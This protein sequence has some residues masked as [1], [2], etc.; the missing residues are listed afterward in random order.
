MIDRLN[1]VKHIIIIVS[2]VSSFRPSL[3]KACW[4]NVCVT[5]RSVAVDSWTTSSREQNR[6]SSDMTNKPSQAYN[7]PVGYGSTTARRVYIRVNSPHSVWKCCYFLLNI[8]H[9]ALQLTVSCSWEG[10]PPKSAAY[11]RVWIRFKGSPGEY[12]ISGCLAP[13]VRQNSHR[14]FAFRMYP[15]GQLREESGPPDPPG[16]LRRWGSKLYLGGLWYPVHYRAAY[17]ECIEF[18]IPMLNH[19]IV[20]VETGSLHPSIPDYI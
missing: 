18:H 4:P 6:Y 15:A 16:Q 1:T 14:I 5:V 9:G 12:V 3:F 2:A 20:K 19:L 17:N 13:P 10:P 8:K 7:H 11:R